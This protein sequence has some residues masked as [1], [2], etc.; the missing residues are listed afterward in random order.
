MILAVSILYQIGFWLIIGYAAGVIST[1]M[2]IA[3]PGEDIEVKTIFRK[4]VV[5]GKQHS[6]TDMVDISDVAD[7]VKTVD[8]ERKLTG[9]ERRA[10]RKAKRDAKKNNQK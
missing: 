1:V 9:K 4:L 5:R 10:A 6:V 3:P 7:V 8:S 2:W